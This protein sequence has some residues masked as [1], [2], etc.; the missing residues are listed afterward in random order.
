MAL[1]QF[2][3]N[4]VYMRSSPVETWSV[5]CQFVTLS[6]TFKRHMFGLH[7]TLLDVSS[8]GVDMAYYYLVVGYKPSN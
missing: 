7:L 8:G 4:W 2:L 1:M 6:K 5:F 3:H